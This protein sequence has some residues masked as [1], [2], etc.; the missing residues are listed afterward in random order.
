MYYSEEIGL[1]KTDISRWRLRS[2]AL[3]RE[4]WH[5][6]SQSECESESEP[7]STFVQWL[8][9]SPDFPS[10]PSSDIHTPDEAARKGADF[11]KLLQLDNGIFPCQY[12]GPMFMTIGYVTANYYSK[13]EIPE[14]YRVEMIRYIVNTAHPVDG[15][16]GL[17]SVDKSTCFGTTMNY[18]CLRLLGMEKDHPVLVK[19]R[20]T[21]H[22][23]G[24]AIKNPHWGKAWLSILNLYEWEG[25]NPAPPELWRLPYW[26]PI[27]PAKWWVHTRA[28]YLPLGYTSA[29]R[30]QCELDPL[31]KEIRNEIYVPS[32]L[33]YESIKFGN[34]RNNVCGV[35]LYYPHTKILDFANSILSKWEA[36]RPKWLLN[37]VNKKVYDL[38]VKEYQNTEYLCIAPVSFAFNMVVTCHYEGSESENFKKLQNRMNDV[39]FHGPQGMTVMGT[40]GVQV[41]DAAFMVQYFFMT[42]LVDDPKYHDMIRKSYLFLV[43][44]Q[45]TENCVDGSFR[46]RRKGAWPFS[47][48]EQGYTVSDCTAE[49]MKAIIMVRNHAS[50]ADIRDEIKDEN[51][52][53]AVE[54][55]LQI[56]NV[57]EWEYGSFSTYEGI[58]APL[59]LEKL[60]PAE[61]FNNI[62]VEY[63]YVECTDSSVLGLT[64]F[65]KYYPD[66]KPELI[67]KT[68]SSAIQYILDSQDNIDGSWY[69]CWGICYTYASMFALEALHTVGL[70]YESSSAVKKGCDFLISKQLPDGGWSESMKGCETHSYVNGE[71]SLVV[72]SAWALIGLILGNYPD[73]EPIKRGIQFLM[74]RQLPTGEWKYED[75]EGVFNHSCAIE[76]PSYRF[77]FPIKALGLYKNKY[78]DKVLV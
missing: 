49:A 70:D 78:G 55:L 19:A 67:Q 24:G 20:K 4:T 40:N 46:D 34:Q 27:H 44:S 9:E 61:V 18:V 23:L 74:K 33:P 57:G 76:Y 65:A 25:V 2:D 71:N 75:I 28:I 6:L 31:L 50:F 12:K 3:G 41:W 32:Q 8:L 36:V 72:Q 45:F 15:G 14:P 39:L 60:N 68:I 30:V 11:L 13:T 64:Y 48:K 56:Q 10:P 29:N 35:D 7:Q 42:G 53:D 38:I 66:Y 69:G 26:L 52:F 16:W 54:V 77:L 51:L 62:M 5:Y 21:L 37:W 43:R 58:K 59:L 73:E 63:P 1:P 47:T 22:R 17:H